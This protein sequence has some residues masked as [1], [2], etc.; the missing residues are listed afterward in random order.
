VNT[1]SQTMAWMMDTYSMHRGHTVAAAVTGKPMAIGGTRGRR[2]AT[3]RGA[4]RCMAAVAS[5]RKLS[6]AG[7]RVAIQGFG[8]VGMTLAEELVAAGAVVVGLADDRDAVSNPSGI[9]IDRA[10][11]WMREHDAIKGLPGA[12]PMPKAEFFG[13]DCDIVVPA[14]LQGEI[15]EAIAG[16]IR[17]KIVAEAAN[18]ATTP[19]GDA[20]LSERGVVLIPDILCTAGAMVLGYF[21]WVQDMQA[22]FW[23]ETEISAEL[24]RIM[25]E[26]VAGVQHMASAEKVDL[27]SAAMMV[28][29]SRVAEA[30]Q[31]R[32]LYP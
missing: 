15:T 22:F 9:A 7:A 6:L 29:V 23:T 16:T 12:E 20:V 1:G 11:E 4:L 17:A 24:D 8:R 30:T 14:G 27:R 32:G 19:A 25:D 5:S 2:S 28:A 3:A 31:L 10:V 13:L 26:A 18:G 21:E